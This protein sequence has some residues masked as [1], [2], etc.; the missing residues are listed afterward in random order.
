MKN[1]LNLSTLLCLVF[2]TGVSCKEDS[3]FEKCDPP[4]ADVT[5]YSDK[6]G[7]L[8]LVDSIPGRKLSTYQFFLFNEEITYLPLEICNSSGLSNILETEPSVDVI[9][10][11]HLYNIPEN[12]Y[13]RTIAF[14]LT[15]I[16]ILKP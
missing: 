16:D 2:L 14:E 7:K 6:K 5:F 1:P 3:H 4:I 11:G 13:V 8:T 12:I 15:H 10:S 9:F